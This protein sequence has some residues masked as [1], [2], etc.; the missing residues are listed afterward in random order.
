MQSTRIDLV[1]HAIQASDEMLYRHNFNH[2]PTSKDTIFTYSKSRRTS[3][4]DHVVDG[5][6]FS[7]RPGMGS[8]HTSRV[9]NL[10]DGKG[11]HHACLDT[12]DQM[13]TG[14]IWF[15]PSA[16]QGVKLSSSDGCSLCY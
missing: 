10:L 1:T 4:S 14:S 5:L 13:I 2:D 6:G 16:F 15:A 11:M 9:R 12:W 7:H 3:G 8:E